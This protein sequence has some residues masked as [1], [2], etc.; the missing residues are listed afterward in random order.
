MRQT[1]RKDLLDNVECGQEQQAERLRLLRRHLA[2]YRLLSP[3][4]MQALEASFDS[5]RVYARRSVICDSDD[6]TSYMVVNGWLAQTIAVK[7]SRRQIVD[8]LL[9]GDICYYFP[10]APAG[11]MHCMQVRSLTTACLAPLT[12]ARLRSLREQFCHVAHAMLATA[13]Q[14]GGRLANQVLRLGRL[15][16]YERT[17]HLMLD[18]LMRLQRVGLATER[19]YKLPLTQGEL[20]DVL[21][22]SSI[23]LHRVLRSLTRERFIELS[24]RAEH[25]SVTVCDVPRLAE[26]AGVGLAG[27][28]HA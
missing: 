23:H 21:G 17:A 7:D 28:C 12:G 18:L 26:L 8:L 15:G 25:T 11:P 24:G 14:A 13:A 27:G 19:S 5:A 16:A 20:S 4:E 1:R 10:D 2:Q 9:P 22:L 3:V 6:D